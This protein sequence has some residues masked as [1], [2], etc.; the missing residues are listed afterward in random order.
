MQRRRKNTRGSILKNVEDSVSDHDKPHVHAATL[1]SKL[2]IDFMKHEFH[3]FDINK[4]NYLE[5]Y[6][7]GVF[8]NSKLA[9]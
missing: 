2:D 1:V 9:L 8:L 7:L 6:E 3:Y 4:K 5:K